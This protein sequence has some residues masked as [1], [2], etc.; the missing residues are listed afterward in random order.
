M[1]SR[2]WKAVWGVV[3]GSSLLMGGC[4]AEV[5]GDDPET[6]GGLETSWLPAH[7]PVR[8]GY[9]WNEQAGRPVW[10]SYAVVDGQAVHGGDMLLGTEQQVEAYTREVKEAFAGERTSQGIA[11][12]G[13][14]YRWP[15]A[16]VPYTIA[17]TLPNPA[18]VTNAIAHWHQKTSV[19]FVLRTATNAAWYPDYVTFRPGS[20]CTAH[21]GRIGGQQFVNLATACD[22]GS[23][24]HEI[25]HAV[26]LWHEHSREDRNAYVTIHPANIQDGMAFAFAQHISDGV[27]VLDYNYGSIMHYGRYAFSKN[28]LPTITAKGGQAIGQNVGLNGMDVNGV[29]RMYP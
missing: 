8:E 25:G 20:G 14:Q 10:V 27:D 26:G 17:S 12:Q 21:V 7:V 16:V 4:G 2:F 11:I 23:T 3:V 1:R 5:N 28:G 22:T 18:R 9:A 19:R 15:G 6:G 13:S 24:I 29:N